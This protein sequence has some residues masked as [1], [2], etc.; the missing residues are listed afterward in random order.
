LD[1]LAPPKKLLTEAKGF[2]EKLGTLP[3]LAL[4]INSP[5]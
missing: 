1:I 2:L 4:L 5:D 3:D